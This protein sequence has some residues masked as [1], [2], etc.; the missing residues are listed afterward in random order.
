MAPAAVTCVDFRI[1]NSKSN[2]QANFL[3]QTSL[4]LAIALGIESQ[5]GSA[6]VSSTDPAYFHCWDMASPESLTPGGDFVP[7]GEVNVLDYSRQVR[8][9]NTSGL[10]AGE[11]ML[12]SQTSRLRYS[13]AQGSASCARRRELEATIDAS[14]NVSCPSS[15]AAGSCYF[16]CSADPACLFSIEPVGQSVTATGAWY[17]V[18]LPPRWLAFSL[19]FEVGMDVCTSSD[20]SEACIA[21]VR[22]STCEDENFAASRTSGLVIAAPTRGSARCES[23]SEV[24]YF[25]PHGTRQGLN[26]HNRKPGGVFPGTW[27]EG[28]NGILH[29]L[30]WVAPPPSPPPPSPS[31][32]CSL[33]SLRPCDFLRLDFPGW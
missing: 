21:L 11:A 27:V 15:L 13:H 22:N 29:L 17:R 8:L 6:V 9:Q 20:P 18:P 2:L 32:A 24:W 5:C 33:R 4:M 23:S 7:D 1:V 10:G 14:W 3:Q 12:L 19:L 26:Y 16:D 30:E 31:A 25:V 28:T